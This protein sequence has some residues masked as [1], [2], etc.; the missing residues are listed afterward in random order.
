[1]VLSREM[2]PE[3]PAD[4][5]AFVVRRFGAARAEAARLTGGERYA[6]EVY[7]AAFT[8]VAL[9]WRW[10]RRRADAILERSLA[11]RAKRWREEQIYE[12]DVRPV[13][14]GRPS[15]VRFVSVALRK[16][17]L[18]APTARPSAQPVAE[19]GIAWC[20]AY[21][22]WRWRRLARTVAAVL[23]AVLVIAE[24]LPGPP[25]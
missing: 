11:R 9:H 1:M 2:Q 7:P 12:V 23:I 6:D 22:R 25:A 5:V 8:D 3:P 21:R 24:M 16:A 17:G 4:Y 15:P 10:Q 13:H 18:L 20:C 14:E 19:A